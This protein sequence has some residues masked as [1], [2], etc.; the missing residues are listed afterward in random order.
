MC[1]FV[2]ITALW[3][4][5]SYVLVYNSEGPVEITVFDNPQKVEGRL[6]ILIVKQAVM[7]EVQQ[8]ILL[9]FSLVIF[10]KNFC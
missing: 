7:V 9:K 2:V 4:C 10:L 3:V 6:S 8:L 5:V 1:P